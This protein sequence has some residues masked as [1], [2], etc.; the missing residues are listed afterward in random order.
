MTCINLGGRDSLANIIE[1]SAPTTLADSQL[2]SDKYNVVLV[3]TAGIT[4]TLP[5]SASAKVV[6]VQQGFEGVG[7]FTVCRT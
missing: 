3:M 6:L 5:S 2:L 7:D 4:I 1:V